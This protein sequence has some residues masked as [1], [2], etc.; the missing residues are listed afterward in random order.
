[1]ERY[2]R[3]ILFAPIGENGQQNI[4]KGHVLII[5]AGALGS[6]VAESLARAGVGK[7]TMVDRDYVD[8]TNLQ[9]QNLYC[10]EDARNHL[11]KAIAAKNRLKAINS[12][13]RIEAHVI[14]AFDPKLLSILE[15]GVDVIIDGTDNFETRFYVNDLAQ[16]Y[17]IPWI[18]GSCVGSCGV[19]F[20]II[21]GETPC[22]R[23]L[24]GHLP[25]YHATCDTA[26]IIAPAVQMTAAY[27]TT[28]ALK[29]LSGEKP[30]DSVAVFDIWQGEHHFIK[31]GKMKNK[32]CPSCGGHPV[33]PALQ[34]QSSADVLCGRDTVQIRH[35]GAF[36]LENMAREMK[37]GGAAVEYNG[38]LIITA[39]EGHRTVL[40]P[41][42]RMLI[43]GTKDK[44]EARSLYQKYFQ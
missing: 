32:D 13:I 24:I 27:E 31:A 20:P 12:T 25:A 33:Y 26:G 19:S 35:P 11:P 7:I 8:E 21:P 23:C 28:E 40:F 43:H 22:L 41:D 42:G 39:L 5:G 44:R 14:D 34:S 36:E 10:E 38:Y 3:Q 2:S 15:E 9:R 37:A 29:L 16:K 6:A 4:S 18:Y 17:R 1:M 30:R